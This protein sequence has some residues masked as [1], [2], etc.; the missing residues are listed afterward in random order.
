MKATTLGN[1][2]ALVPR[3]SGDDLQALAATC[4]TELNDL[5]APLDAHNFSRR[6]KETLDARATELLT[7]YGY[8]HVLERY[9]LHFTL[10]GHVTADEAT[11]VTRA[12]AP[13]V[14]HLHTHE[15]LV[16]DRLCL[17]MEP[18]PDREFQRIADFTLATTA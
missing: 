13:K 14:L 11:K 6:Q 18:A 4:V 1:F 2:V 8:P 9:Q 12:V 10:T 3:M 16:L 17:F 15:P 7:R 5:R